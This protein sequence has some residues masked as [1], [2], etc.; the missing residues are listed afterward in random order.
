MTYTHIIGVPCAA[1]RVIWAGSDFKFIGFM[2]TGDICIPLSI[3]PGRFNAGIVT[4]STVTVIT[5]FGI[6]EIYYSP[7]TLVQIT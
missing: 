6:C 3:K 4:E 5:K 7:G 1:R 2:E